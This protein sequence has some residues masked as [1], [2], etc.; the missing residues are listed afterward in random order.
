MELFIY[1]IENKIIILL[2]TGKNKQM[3]IQFF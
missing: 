1:I 3:E 2:L